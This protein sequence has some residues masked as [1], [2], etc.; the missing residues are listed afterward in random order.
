MLM[1][2]GKAKVSKKVEILELLMS[3]KKLKSVLI[4]KEDA[5]VM[6]VF[7]MV[8][9]NVLTV[10]KVL[11]L[12]SHYLNSQSKANGEVN[13]K[14]LIVMMLNLVFQTTKLIHNYFKD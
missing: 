7:G 13:L 4:R 9:Q 3:V 14:L 8:S 10:T 12:L 5:F 11:I 1:I 6:V 2:I